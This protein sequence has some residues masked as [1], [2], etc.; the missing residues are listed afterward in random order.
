MGWSRG[1]S[2]FNI[3]SMAKTHSGNRSRWGR[4][5]WPILHG[6]VWVG[7]LAVRS[8]A[9]TGNLWAPELTRVELGG[10][11]TLRLLTVN[12]RHRGERF[13]AALV[14]WRA[15]PGD[16]VVVLIGAPT[17]DQGD[18]DVGRLLG[19]NPSAPG[20]GLVEGPGFGGLPALGKLGLAI[21]SA[22][23]FN[24]DGATELALGSPY[25]SSTGFRAGTVSVL[26]WQDGPSAP[27]VQF[28]RSTMPRANFGTALD[29]VGDVNRDGF[30]DLVVGAPVMTG[31]WAEEGA[32]Y[33]Y[34]GGADGLSTNSVWTAWGGQAGMR[35]GEEVEAAGDVNGDR[36]ADVL[37]A[38]PRWGD[39]LP[40]YGEVRLYLGTRE[41]LQSEPAWIYR[42]RRPYAKAGR[43][44]LG[45]VDLN[46]DG[47]MDVAVGLPSA[48]APGGMGTTGEVHF[49]FGNRQGLNL[50]PDWIWEGST[51]GNGFGDSVCLV[52][53]MNGDG[54]AE[55]AVGAPFTPLVAKHQGV[56]CVFPGNS[57]G[58]STTPLLQVM[59]GVPHGRYGY[60]LAALGDVDGD[61]LADLG[62]G[63][64]E[65]APPRLSEGRCDLV[66]GSRGL[67]GPPMVLEALHKPA[68][69]ASITNTLLATIVELRRPPPSAVAGAGLGWRT[70]DGSLAAAVAVLM[71]VVCLAWR[72][73]RRKLARMRHRL[74]DFVGSELS[75]LDHQDPRMRRV[76]E[77][78]KAMVWAV[79][80]ERPTVAGLVHQLA[81][82]AF[83]YAS[84]RS[85]DL[86]LELPG[87]EVGSAGVRS[88]MAELA[89]ATVRVAL[90]NVVEHAQATSAVLRIRVTDDQ[91]SV[92]VEDNGVGFREELLQ[93]P[94]ARRMGS[95]GLCGI[96]GRVERCKGSFSV[97]NVSGSGMRLTVALP[98]STSHA[99]RWNGFPWG[100]K[101][102]RVRPDPLLLG[103][104]HDPTG[105]G[106]ARP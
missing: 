6:L 10:G 89:H 101:K 23:D 65:F 59:G 22:G 78:L 21:S 92:E 62:I 3:E 102:T 75:Q 91:L 52:G 73:A 72:S 97:D 26:R 16:P 88:G 39:G 68:F 25:A 12:G 87:P 9:A 98:I 13:G 79:K 46:R 4:S 56:L 30:D 18:A 37:V 95:Q 105:R 67:G 63:S 58:F 81:D 32:A 38:A 20:G 85:L 7:C 74:H 64:P 55:L 44:L 48:N 60:Q 82:W 49:F 45:G 76:T 84:E 86:R 104:T 28:L 11:H 36:F 57:A 33:L 53:D 1:T 34:L 51:P 94:H 5:W 35:L 40:G 50:E 19:W 96:R 83:E 100:R 47:F 17:F 70:W 61:G 43:G 106:G 77:E 71:G 54:Y 42:G 66:F 29:A 8:N 2:S 99:S 90:S 24:G 15:K 80:Q 69:R 41:G 14:P 27:H 103:S 93:E 31:D